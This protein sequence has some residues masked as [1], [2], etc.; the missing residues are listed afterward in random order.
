LVA[1]LG[2]MLCLSLFDSTLAI[3]MHPMFVV[4]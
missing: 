1:S 3:T 2:M 4:D